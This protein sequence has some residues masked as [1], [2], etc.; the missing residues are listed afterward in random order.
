MQ[1]RDNA[2]VAIGEPL[3]IYDMPLVAEKV[4]LHPELGR[5]GPRHHT[6]RFE[7]LERRKQAGNVGLSLRFAPSVTGLEIDLVNAQGCCLLD[8]DRH[9]L[10]RAGSGR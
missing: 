10:K 8:P 2:N 4:S 6:A 1:D 7:L 9:R 3:P 5:H